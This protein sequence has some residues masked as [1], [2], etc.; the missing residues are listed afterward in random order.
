M[1]IARSLLLL[2]LFLGEGARAGRT[3]ITVL[4]TTDLHG[5]ILP[6]DY[7]ANLSAPRGLA[8]IASLIRDARADAPNSLLIDCGDTIQ[9]SPLE[10][11]YQSYVRTGHLPLDLTFQGRPLQADPMMLSMNHLRYDA[12]VVGNHEFNFGWKNLA[13]ARS[14]A[15]FPWLSANTEVVDRN[16]GE[17]FAPYL[18]KTVAGIKIAVIGI[19]TPAVPAWEKPETI[20]G[21]RFSDGKEAV[22]RTIADLRRDEHPDLVI[23]AA[24]AGLDRDPK[25]GR[26]QDEN[27]HEN[28]VYQIASGVEGVDAIVFGHTHQELAQ[29]Q[30]GKVLLTQ[31]KNWGI[32]LARIDFVLEGIPGGPWKVLRKSSRVIRVTP[33]TEADPEIMA[34][35]RPYEELAERYLNHPV[36]QAD[37]ALDGRLGRVEDT[38][39]VD[40]VQAVELHYAKADVS[41]T[42]MFN[43]HVIV[44]KGPV[45]VRQIAALYVYDNE[46]YAIEGDGKMVKD[47]LENAARY[48][49]GCRGESCANGPLINARVIGFNYD[50]A[51]GVDYEIDLTQPEGERIRNLK[52]HGKPLDP[53]QKLRIAVNNYRAAGSAGY[54]MFRG[55]KIVWRSFDD[56]RELMV[57]YYT[58]RKKLPLEADGNWRIVPPEAEAALRREALAESPRLQ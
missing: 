27:S 8:K 25:S 47:A 22:Q 53:S 50:M 45:T 31:P 57:R 58:E 2:A 28:M 38:A 18:L 33:E 40:A 54:S 29:Y 9:G 4:A 24:H 11:V 55:A 52:F 35:A 12:M 41:F 19:T 1:R 37:R 13:R 49:T 51:E 7:F 42:A 5:N 48:F 14:G 26:I 3:A 21:L 16:L 39:L 46:L 23:V 6:V 30:I 43:P 56:I 10:Y 17:P 34:I 36:A 44:A 15:K 20:A 32:S